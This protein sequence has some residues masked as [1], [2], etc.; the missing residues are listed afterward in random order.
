MEGSKRDII[1]M[2]E[3]CGERT[4]LGGPLAVWRSE[5]HLRVRVRRAAYPRRPSRL[6]RVEQGR[7]D[8]RCQA[9]DL[10]SLPLTDMPNE[11]REVKR[12]G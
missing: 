9:T 2:C 12:R 8:R 4:V 3:V 11:E 1:L 6:R 7:R 5:H 10:A